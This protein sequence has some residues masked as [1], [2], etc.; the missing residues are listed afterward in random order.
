MSL[1]DCRIPGIGDMPE[2]E[3]EFLPDGFDHVLGG[4]VGIGE[5]SMVPVAASI[6]NAVFHATGW[7]PTRAPI[8]PSDVIRGVN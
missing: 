5:V 8:R 6:A 3:V 2:M 7:R 4:G 1:E